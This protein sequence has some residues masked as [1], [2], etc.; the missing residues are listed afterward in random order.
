MLN[1]EWD[2]NKN[3][4]NKNKHKISFEAASYVFFDPR[5]KHYLDRVVVNEQRMHVIGNALD[6]I[7]I[8]VVYTKR[9]DNIRIISARKA[10]KK[11]RLFYYNTYQN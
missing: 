9:G 7:L 10:N 4:I 1:F 8:L 3:K 11:E 5:S 2:E 6:I